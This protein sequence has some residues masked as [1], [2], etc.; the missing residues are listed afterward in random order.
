MIDVTCVIPVYANPGELRVTFD[1]FLQV[2]TSLQDLNFELIVV[3]GCLDKP[4]KSVISTKGFP[5]NCSI[6]YCNEFDFGPYDAM[7]KGLDLATGRWIWFLNSGDQV[8]KFC[9]PKSLLS[10]CSLIV[11]SWISSSIQRSFYPT[12]DSGISHRESCEIGYGLCHQS[13]LFSA[14]YCRSHRFDF[15]RYRYAAELKFF[16]PALIDNDYLVD[17]HFQCIYDSSTGLSKRF[18]W[19]HWLEVMRVYQHYQLPV[20]IHRIIYRSISAVRLQVRS[21][22]YRQ[23][24]Q[25]F[26]I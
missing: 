7:N 5:V 1:S 6:V 20:P 24:H 13:M 26:R 3:D 18:A 2:A 11:G 23:W 25:I 10:D 8:H 22:I 14:S 15:P 19:R 9:L 21:I 16:I 12:L 4:S 17:H